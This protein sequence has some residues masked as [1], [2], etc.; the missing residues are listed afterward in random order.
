MVFGLLGAVFLVQA[1]LVNAEF[2]YWYQ[3]RIA[4]ASGIERQI[5]ELDWAVKRDIV[6]ELLFNVG[7]WL[8]MMVRYRE[9]GAQQ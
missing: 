3:E 9:K 2:A 4:A 6:D 7:S 1:Y 8:T 5:L